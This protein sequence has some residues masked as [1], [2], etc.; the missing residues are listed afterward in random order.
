MFAK[1]SLGGLDNLTSGDVQYLDQVDATSQNLAYVSP[2]GTAIVKVD[3]TTNVPYNIKR[4]SVSGIVLFEHGDLL[5]YDKKVRITSKD[6]Y[7]VGSLWII[8][9]VHM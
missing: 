3:N 6:I 5:T 7:P 2:Q 8:D 1:I 9:A 4:N